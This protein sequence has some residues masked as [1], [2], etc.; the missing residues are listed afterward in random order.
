MSFLEKNLRLEGNPEKKKYRYIIPEGEYTIKHSL[1][2]G[3][4][5]QNVDRRATKSELYFPVFESQKLTPE[6]QQEVIANYPYPHEISKEGVI[7]IT[8]KEER[9][10]KQND[11][12]VKRKLL[13]NINFALRPKKKRITE[14]PSWV[15]KKELKEGKRLKKIIAEKKKR[16][17]PPEIPE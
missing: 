12:S 10:Q 11:E 7:R 8:S 4:G 5:G 16:R 6:E 3:S 2:S 1:S 9:S 15:K 14:K 13:E 17:Q